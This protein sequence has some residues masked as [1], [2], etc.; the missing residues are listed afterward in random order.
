MS[1]DASFALETISRDVRMAGYGGCKG[2]SFAYTSAKPYTAASTFDSPKGLSATDPTTKS[3]PKLF[4]VLAKQ[5]IGDDFSLNLFA[6]ANGLF[7]ASNVIAGASRGTAGATERALLPTSTEYTI[8]TTTPILHVM[9]GSPQALQV[10]P[11]GGLI[12]APP[13]LG[14]NFINLASDPYNWSNNFGA[15]TSAHTMLLL[16]ADCNGSELVRA[17]SISAATG[18][19][20]MRLELEAALLNTYNYDALVTPIT[21]STYFLATRKNAKNP[22]L[23]RRYFN[24]HTRNEADIVKEELVPNVEAISF[25]YGINT[26]NHPASAVAPFVPN[27]PTNQADVYRSDASTF[28]DFV[29]SRIVSVRIGMILVSEDAKIANATDSSIKWLEGVYTPPSTTDNRLRRAYST[30]IS[31]RNRT[32]L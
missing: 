15:S 8:S 21:A 3:S 13:T 7:S 10:P 22:S 14:N 25:Q 6:S 32:G 20:P 31:V 16:I 30:T 29:R 4:R 23:Y 19:V 1:E 17:T 5:S 9:G 24:G 26:N 12:T 28:T 27:D 18:A 11:A 2:V